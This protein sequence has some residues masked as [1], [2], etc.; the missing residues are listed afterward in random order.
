MNRLFFFWVKKKKTGSENTVA[1]AS[2]FLATLTTDYY[3]EWVYHILRNI[4]V[5]LL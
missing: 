5:T 4:C 2:Y 1:Y 3:D